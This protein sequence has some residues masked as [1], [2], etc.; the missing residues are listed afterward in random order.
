MTTNASLGEQVQ[1]VMCFALWLVS[2]MRK[3]DRPISTLLHEATDTCLVEHSF[4]GY[5]TGMNKTVQPIPNVPTQ[6]CLGRGHS[7]SHAAPARRTK[8]STQH[9]ANYKVQ[10]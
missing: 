5:V 7:L 9:Q 6:H 3:H 8:T 2:M 1:Q 10:L 4:N